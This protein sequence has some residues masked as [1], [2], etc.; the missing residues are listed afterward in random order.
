[1]I[2]VAQLQI[3]NKSSLSEESKRD[4]ILFSSSLNIEQEKQGLGEFQLQA[5][6]VSSLPP[7]LNSTPKHRSRKKT[8]NIN[9]EMVCL[10]ILSGAGGA[11]P[12]SSKR[13]HFETTRTTQRGESK[14]QM[15]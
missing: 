5:G 12:S 3:Q 11:L 9:V 2:S 10:K 6:F 1:L 13:H 15:L 4:L 14:N 7:S 8:T